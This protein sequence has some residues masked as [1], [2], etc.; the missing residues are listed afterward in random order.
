MRIITNQKLIRRN[1]KIGQFTSLGGL[2]LLVIGLILSFTN[3]EQVWLSLGALLL[4]FSMSQLGIFFGNKFARSPRADQALNKALKGMDRYHTLYH[5]IA[6]SDHLLAGPSGIWIL[7]VRPQRGNITFEKGRWR[8]RG[9]FGLNYMKIFA[10]ENIGRPDLDIGAELDKFKKFLDKHIPG[11]S[12]PEPQAVL[13]FTNQQ[14]EI[15]ADNAPIPTMAAGKLKDYIRKS[16]KDRNVRLAPEQLN[17]LQ[18][19]LEKNV[20]EDLVEE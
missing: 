11:V 14:A 16:A 2:V 5:F 4:G 12:F 7:L 15:Y 10:Q 9:G 17:K 1:A 20:T 13:L 3:Q 6:P 19:V 18:E 8:Q